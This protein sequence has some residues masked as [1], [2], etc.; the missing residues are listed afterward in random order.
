MV[1]IKGC[2]RGSCYLRPQ[3][4]RIRLYFLPKRRRHSTT[5]HA[6][7]CH[8]TVF[9]IVTA[10]VKSQISYTVRYSERFCEIFREVWSSSSKQIIPVSL[11]SLFTAHLSTCLSKY[12]QICWTPFHRHLMRTQLWAV[13]CDGVV[14]KNKNKKGYI[15]IMYTY[16]VHTDI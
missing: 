10:L 9:F 5:L 7:T 16:T 15:Y 4:R 13:L 8:K 1:E 14:N 11:C 12:W 3:D 6:V 2:L